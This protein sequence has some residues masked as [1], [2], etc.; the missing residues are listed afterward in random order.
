MTSTALESSS[1]KSGQ[2]YFLGW[3]F[4]RKCL[5]LLALS[6]IGLLQEIGQESPKTP[7]QALRCVHQTRIASQFRV[8][9][10][11][12]Y[13]ENCLQGYRDL[14]EKCWVGM[15]QDRPDFDFVVD[16]LAGLSD[17]HRRTAPSLGNWRGV[18]PA[19]ERRQRDKKSLDPTPSRWKTGGSGRHESMS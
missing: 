12:A 14:M 11:N 15:P 6:P 8:N 2:E 10:S 1:L 9:N 4:R 13:Y 16:R 19:S 18:R 17:S 3:K 7:R 5:M